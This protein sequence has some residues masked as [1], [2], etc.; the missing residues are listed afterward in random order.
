MSALRT[1]GFRPQCSH[2]PASQVF[3]ARLKSRLETTGKSKRALAR[4]C[5]VDPSLVTRWTNGQAEPRLDTLILCAQALDTT[6]EW[7]IG[8]KEEAI[9]G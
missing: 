2:I 6:P 7:L 9:S 8:W 3:P 5:Q 4:E 1:P